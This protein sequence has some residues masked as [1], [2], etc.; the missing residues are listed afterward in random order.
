MNSIANSIGKYTLNKIPRHS[1]YKLYTN[2]RVWSKSTKVKWKC[3]VELQPVLLHNICV[4][5][6]YCAMKNCTIKPHGLWEK[7]GWGTKFKTSLTHF[8]KDRQLIK[9]QQFYTC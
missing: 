8:K 7:W 6:N 9:L 5:I 2:L 3:F 1:D 4:P